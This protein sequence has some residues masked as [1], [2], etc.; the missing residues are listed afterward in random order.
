MP[1][2]G[3]DAVVAHEVAE[4]SLGAEATP[5]LLPRSEPWRSL[6]H[7]LGQAEQL[8]GAI[9]LVVILA[10][11]LA[12]VVQRYVPG[13][14]PWTGE[15]ARLSMVWATFL[16]AG[17]LSAHDRHIAIHVADFV[18]KGRG[19]AALKLF[20]DVL[21]LATCL[22]LL[23]ATYQLI[24]SDIGQVTAAAELPLKFVNAVPIVG[25]AL[26]AL[27]CTLG[28]FLIDLPGVLGRQEVPA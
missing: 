24:D 5:E 4:E 3:E 23:Y 21:V 13:T 17:Y 25:F 14:W 1:N 20:V 6:L 15:V 27:R 26:T 28:I 19:L 12:Q 9:L 10:L 8:V 2:D 22:V 7:G 11:V 16:M 18:L